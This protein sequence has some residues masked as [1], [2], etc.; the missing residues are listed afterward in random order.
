MGS[1]PEA[2]ARGPSR[3]HLGSLRPHEGRHEAHRHASGTT[4]LE[5][6]EAGVADGL[7]RAHGRVVVGHAPGARE[8][9]VHDAGVRAARVD[10]PRALA[11]VAQAAGDAPAHLRQGEA[12][13]GRDGAQ[14]VARVAAAEVGEPA[15]RTHQRRE[16]RPDERPGEQEQGVEAAHAEVLK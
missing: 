2:A 15:P 11:D 14:S 12:L 6:R 13:V 8:H 9:E 5:H 16:E 7:E 4:P 3:R 10:R 1:R